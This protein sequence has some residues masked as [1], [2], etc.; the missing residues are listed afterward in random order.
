MVNGMNEISNF[1][2]IIQIAYRNIEKNTFDKNN[3]MFNA[4]KKVITSIKSYDDGEISLGQN[5]FDHSNPVDVKNGILLIETD[6][7]GWS[8][9]MQMRSKYIL[10]G[11]NMYV[12]ELNISGLAFRIRGS[13]AILHSASYDEIL[14]KENEK[15]LEKLKKEELEL[16]KYKNNDEK[17]SANVELPKE[18]LD[19]FDSIRQSMLTNNKNK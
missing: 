7:P 11:L 16:N 13:N 17:K 14:K 8:Q 19:K 4:W 12:P 15:S 5:L 1:S 18:L 2:D 3:K 10:K 9:M 6:H